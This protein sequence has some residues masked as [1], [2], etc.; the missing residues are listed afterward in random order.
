MNPNDC[1]WSCATAYPI[2]GRSP[3]WGTFLMYCFGFFIEVGIDVFPQLFII[4]IIYPLGL[5]FG[6]FASSIKE[7]VASSSV[8]FTTPDTTVSSA[9]S[10]QATT[11]LRRQTAVHLELSKIVLEIDS[12]FS[13]L[14]FLMYTGDLMGFI[15]TASL[16]LHLNNG[17]PK[18]SIDMELLPVFMA[19]VFISS[20]HAMIRTSFGVWL[21]EKVTQLYSV[22]ILF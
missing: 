5:R 15:A 20:L 3:V 7:L 8:V 12:T 9:G 11:I 17:I 14:F 13:F 2:L 1:G 19:L 4:M 18:G 21:S 22:L 6:N 16:G 10:L